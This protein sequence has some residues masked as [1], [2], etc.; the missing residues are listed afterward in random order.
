M[1]QV[2]SI[3]QSNSMQVVNNISQI[4]NEKCVNLCVNSTDIDVDIV[5][6]T[7]GNI[8]LGTYCSVNGA[9]CTLKSALSN[10]ITNVLT[11]TQKSTEKDEED[12]TNFLNT[13][14]EIKLLSHT[15]TGNEYFNANVVKITGFKKLYDKNIDINLFFCNNDIP[16]YQRFS[17]VKSYIFL[18]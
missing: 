17:E 11:S 10:T 18:T 8:T 14:A 4:S 1:G 6:S 16:F 12:P 3:A 5:N 13:L 9:S 7:A 15:S 2:Q